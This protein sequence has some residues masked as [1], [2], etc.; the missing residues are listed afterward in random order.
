MA[1]LTPQQVR[2]L[3]QT[4]RHLGRAMASYGRANIPAQADRNPVIFRLY[5]AERALAA[6]SDQMIAALMIR[7]GTEFELDL[8]EIDAVTNL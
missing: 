2:E 5:K 7:T 4:I 1:E 3:E 6:A 8:A